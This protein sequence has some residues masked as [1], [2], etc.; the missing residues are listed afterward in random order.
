VAGDA[1]AFYLGKLA[2]PL[3][4][5]I[6]Y[7]RTPEWV[8]NQVWIY[9][10]WLVPA[11]L[12]ALMWRRR[13]QLPWLLA[14]GAILLAALLP[15]LGLIP[16]NFQQYSTVADRY[17][18]LG[19][20]GPAM[21]LACALAHLRRGQKTVAG[22]CVLFLFA[23]AFRSAFQT[24]SWYNSPKL[25]ENALVVNPRS[26]VA[27]RNHAVALEE[28]GRIDEAIAHLSEALRIRPEYVLARTSLASLLA[29]R[30]QIQ[31][32]STHLQEVLRLRPNDA[33]R[34]EAHNNLGTILM[35]QGN[36]SGAM[37]HFRATLRLQPNNML[38]HFNLGQLLYASHRTDLGIAHLRKA[39]QLAPDNM[40]VQSVL[41]QAQQTLKKRKVK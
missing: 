33:V 7:G 39:V 31:A 4:L 22:L 28:Q 5:G 15:V 18:Y 29:Q 25:Y 41:A 24:L 35:M 36:V 1:L 20:L 6:D 11:A 19:L 12:A 34:S 40:A 10:I 30:G 26:W 37:E 14:G 27:H 2:W 21:A 13:K 23:L 16:F 32:A 38:A 8:M 17:L 9:V 3:Q